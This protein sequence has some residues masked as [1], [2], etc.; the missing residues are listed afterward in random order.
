MIL[1]RA[2]KT[3]RSC[4]SVQFDKTSLLISVSSV[5]HGE[6]TMRRETSE[7]TVSLMVDTVPYK[8]SLF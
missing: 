4:L 3:T 2:R 8:V 6:A 5:N 1:K 7:N